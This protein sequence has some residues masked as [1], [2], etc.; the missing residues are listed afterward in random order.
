MASA[1]FGDEALMSRSVLLAALIGAATLAGCGGGGSCDH[2]GPATHYTLGGTVSGLA[3]S[4]LTLVNNGV[5]IGTFGYAANGSYPAFSG[6]YISGTSYAVTVQTQPTNPSQTC[7]VTNGTGTIDTANVMNIVVTCTTNPARYVYVANGSS[8]NVSAYSVNDA[9]GALTVITQSPFIVGHLPD[10]IAV[11]PTGA[12]VYVANKGD[13]TI[14]AFTIDRSTGALTPVTG[15]PFPTGLSPTSLA[16]DPSSSYVY[17][18]SGSSGTVSAYAITSGTGVLTPV[19]GT[20]FPAGAGPSSVTVSPDESGSSGNAYVANQTGGTV[21]LY[22]LDATTGA[23]TV[24]SAS[25]LSVGGGP[26]AVVIDPS[27]Q[28]LYLANGTLGVSAYAQSNGSGEFTVIPGSPFRAGGTPDSVAVAVDPYDRFVYS[29]N[30]ASSGISGY[31]I[32][33]ASGALTAIGGSPF[34]A[35][36]EPTSVAVDPTGSFVY[37]ANAGSGNVSAYAIEAATGALTPVGSPYPAGTMPSAI[38]ISD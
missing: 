7:V 23:L 6:S 35:G 33:A 12:Y 9:S 15:S 26:R 37:V 27:N 38:A 10:A 18:S 19:S 1:T 25:P 21:S 3:G 24:L 17:A 34:L 32:D 11:D 20:P 2:C 8:N 4:R 29:A 14:S 5:A 13:A 30:Y 28:F 36:S 31:T 16:I 22:G